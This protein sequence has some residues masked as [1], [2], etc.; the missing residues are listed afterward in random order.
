MSLLSEEGAKLILIF[1]QTNI[2]SSSRRGV[3]VHDLYER[4]GWPPVQ[5]DHARE[6]VA[7]R[8]RATVDKLV[9]HLKISV[10]LSI[11]IP[12]CAVHVI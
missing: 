9:M 12:I 4:A 3:C 2:S 8:A 6:P 11:F 5:S 7:A 10:I 1:E